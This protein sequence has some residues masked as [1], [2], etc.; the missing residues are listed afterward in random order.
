M[1]AHEQHPPPQE[2][3]QPPRNSESLAAGIRGARVVSIPGA[4]HSSSLEAPEAVMAALREIL[5]APAQ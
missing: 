4:G 3:A 1:T 2:T 5:A